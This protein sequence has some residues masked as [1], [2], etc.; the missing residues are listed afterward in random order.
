MLSSMKKGIIKTNIPRPVS[1]NVYNKPVR[2]RILIS[3]FVIVCLKRAITVNVTHQT[4]SRFWL[5]SVAE[6]K[7]SNFALRLVSCPEDR[8]GSYQTFFMLNSTENK[9]Y[10]AHKCKCQQLLAF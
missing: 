9:I 8:S 1:L 6:Q 2:P 7:Y 10:A 4:K 5:V 3:A